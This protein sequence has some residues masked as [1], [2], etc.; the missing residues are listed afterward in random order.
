MLRNAQE[1]A[2]VMNSLG[3]IWSEIKN[4]VDICE[5]PF[6]DEPKSKFE[7]WISTDGDYNNILKNK[8]LFEIN[9]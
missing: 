8:S 5:S 7:N 1:Y 9:E 4:I 2:Y 6:Y 3:M